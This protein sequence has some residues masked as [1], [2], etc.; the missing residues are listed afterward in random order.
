MQE[1]RV[2]TLGWKDPLAKE[3]STHSSILAWRI[4]RTEEHGSLQSMGLQRLWRDWA[5]FTSLLKPQRLGGSSFS[6]SW[7]F[8]ADRVQEKHVLKLP[9][10]KRRMAGGGQKKEDRCPK[11]R[12]LR[13]QTCGSQWQ[14]GERS[15]RALKICVSMCLVVSTLHNPM[16]CRILEWIA[17]SSSRESSRPRDQTCIS[18]HW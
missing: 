4:P 2:W 11:L 5:T 17:I 8:L 6:N 10:E 15:G 13:P 18:L 1:I 14:G 9:W 16:D 12:K 3:M 7:C